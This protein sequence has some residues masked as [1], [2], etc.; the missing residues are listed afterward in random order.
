MT[1][2]SVSRRTDRQLGW[3]ISLCAVVMIGGRIPLILEQV[4]LFAPWWTTAGLFAVS[5][6]AVSAVGGL[7]LPLAVLRPSGAGPPR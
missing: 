2:V 5:L 3:L 1:P 4:P 6:V 7:V